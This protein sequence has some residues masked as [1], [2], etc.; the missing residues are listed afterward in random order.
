MRPYKLD[1][2]VVWCLLV[3]GKNVDKGGPA[4]TSTAAGAPES[5]TISSSSNED[6]RQLSAALAHL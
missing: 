3:T 4:K 1:E 6:S 5:I 2:G